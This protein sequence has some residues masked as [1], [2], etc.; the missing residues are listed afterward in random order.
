MTHTWKFLCLAVMLSVFAVPASLRAGDPE[1]ANK[2][3]TD[4]EKLDA[5]L[6]QMKDLRTELKKEIRD[7]SS[8]ATAKN[9]ELD[10]RLKFLTDRVERLER[11]LDRLSATPRTSFFQPAPVPP[12]NNATGTILLQNT[13]TDMATVVLNG[14]AYQVPPGQTLT[15]PNQPGGEYTYEVLANGYGTIRGPVTRNLDSNRTLSIYVYPMR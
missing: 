6:N 8:Q 4:A 15:L 14:R 3:L 12:A 13:W 10:D 11:S 7:A 9:Q 5:I 2:Q 1:K